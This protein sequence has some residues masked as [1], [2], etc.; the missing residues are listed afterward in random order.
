[1]NQIARRSSQPIVPIPQVDGIIIRLATAADIAFCDQMQKF[2]ANKLGFMYWRCYEEAVSIGNSLY[3]AEDARRVPMG[4]ILAKDRYS[5]QDHVG[6]VYQLAVAPVQM[7]AKIGA[8]LLKAFIA[9][10]A[11][12]MRLLSCYCAQ[13]LEANHFWEQMGFLPIAFR[14]GSRRTQR[15]HIFWQRR[16][17]SGD[18]STPFWFPSSTSR[19]AVNEDR[20]VI[21]IPAGVHWSEA[22]PVL[23]PSLAGN[24]LAANGLP[25]PRQKQLPA[26]KPVLSYRERMEKQRASSR[27]LQGRL[28]GHVRVQSRTGIVHVP[29]LDDPEKV[30]EVQAKKKPAKPRAKVS[31]EHKAQSRELRDRFLE[32]LNAQGLIESGK[33]DPSRLLGDVPLGRVGVF[34][35]QSRPQIEHAPIPALQPDPVAGRS[36]LGV[37]FDPVE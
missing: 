29:M 8:N 22:K 19:G 37:D 4:F 12:G 32:E 21:P 35:D 24:G 27:H 2:H 26:A 28:P 17:R 10:A 7:R 18:V 9:G 14:T 6:I 34:A 13:D 15:C 1:M 25:L 23:L 11:W 36:G 33:Y 3:I 30:A 20:L 5:S 31:A 16:V